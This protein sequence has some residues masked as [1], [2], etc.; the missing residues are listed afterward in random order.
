MKTDDV[1]A[2]HVAAGFSP[3]TARFLNLKQTCNCTLQHR[4]QCRHL[5]SLTKHNVITDFGGLAPFRANMTSTT[6]RKY[7]TQCLSSAENRAT[8]TCN[9]YRKFLEIWNCR[10]WY[11]LSDRQTD[12]HTD[13]LIAILYTHSPY[14]HGGEVIN[15]HFNTI[16]YGCDATESV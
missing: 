14:C 9:L 13:T 8:A 7:I 2:D 5:V 4:P 12:R 11:M 1:N 3:Q 15:C 6:N 16:W 10:F